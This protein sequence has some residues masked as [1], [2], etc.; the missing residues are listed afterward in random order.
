LESNSI[1]ALYPAELLKDL[2]KTI[3]TV[4]E[5]NGGKNESCV[6]IAESEVELQAVETEYELKDKFSEIDTY[7]TADSQRCG[8]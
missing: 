1:K 5:C 2:Q 6:I 4:A 7:I 3:K 8:N